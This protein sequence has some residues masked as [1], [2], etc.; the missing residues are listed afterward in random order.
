[1]PWETDNSSKDIAR[2][3]EQIYAR[4][5]DLES[6]P[7][8]LRETQEAVDYYLTKRELLVLANP[9]VFPNRPE[10][11]AELPDGDD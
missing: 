11:T 6:D 1:M 3:T 10:Y 8:L 5:N 4:A 7:T 2:L 9:E